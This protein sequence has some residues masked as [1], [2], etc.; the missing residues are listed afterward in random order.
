M[1]N[2]VK[3]LESLENYVQVIVE[4]KKSGLSDN[5]FILRIVGNYKH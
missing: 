3:E 2:F 1:Q 4:V 5:D